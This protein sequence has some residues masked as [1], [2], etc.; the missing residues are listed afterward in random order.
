MIKITCLDFAY[1]KDKFIIKNFSGEFLK[2]ERICLRAPSG[3]GKTTFLR[4]IASL[5]KP[6]KCKIDISK[7]LK[8][9]FCFQE[10]DLFPWYTAL[11]NVSIV[12]DKKRA[13]EILSVFDL[14]DSLDKYPSELSGGMRKRVSLARAAAYK[15]DVLLIDEGFTGIEKELKIRIMDY[16]KEEFKNSLII[17]ST[18]DDFEEEYFKTRTV[19]I[20]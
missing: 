3:V 20:K 18:H 16:L 12:S 14:S 2:G 1:E 15:G 7:N 19:Y 5:E 4:L 9:S 10:N 13:E 8:L 6:N 17:F 11:Q